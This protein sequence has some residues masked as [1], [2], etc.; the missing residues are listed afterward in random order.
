MSVH[1]CR[2]LRIVYVAG[3]RT[4]FDPFDG[5]VDDEQRHEEPL[6]RDHRLPK[7]ILYLDVKPRCVENTVDE[8][9]F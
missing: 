5:F 6:A 1:Q 3:N 8:V 9:C 7:A 2:R 4:V